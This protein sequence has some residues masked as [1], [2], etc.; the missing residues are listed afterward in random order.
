LKD[1][2]AMVASAHQ[3]PDAIGQV[4]VLTGLDAWHPSSGKDLFESDWMD[5]GSHP[6]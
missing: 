6:A 5:A 4:R 3:R 2:V 1:A